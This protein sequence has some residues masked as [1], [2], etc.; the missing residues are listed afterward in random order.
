MSMVD[1]F[2][3]FFLRTIPFQFVLFLFNKTVFS[4]TFATDHHKNEQVY[5]TKQT[6]TNNNTNASH[7]F[8]PNYTYRPSSSQGNQST[9]AC[10]GSLPCRHLL[11]VLVRHH[12]HWNNN[13]PRIFAVLSGNRRS[14]PLRV[15]MKSMI[16]MLSLVVED[17]LILIRVIGCS[18]DL[19]V[20]TMNYTIQRTIRTIVKL[21]QLPSSVPSTVPVDDSSR[22]IM[23]ARTETKEEEGIHLLPSGCLFR[24]RTRA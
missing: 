8:P 11:L 18:V 22:K 24:T 5:S 19:S 15:S 4:T 23:T 6:F 14:P 9:A 7:F 10:Y 13:S 1:S 21:L 2:F 17:S 20:T 3:F 12:Q 16:K